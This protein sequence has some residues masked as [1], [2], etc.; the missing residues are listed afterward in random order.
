MQI[1][2]INKEL[3][4]YPTKFENGLKVMLDILIIGKKRLME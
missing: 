3:K 4:W 1:L 2:K